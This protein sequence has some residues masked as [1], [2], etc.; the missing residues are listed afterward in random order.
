MPVAAKE[1]LK[2]AVEPVFGLAVSGRVAQAKDQLLISAPLAEVA[3]NVQDGPPFGQE[4]AMTGS[5]PLIGDVAATLD[6]R[7]AHVPP[8]A[9]GDESVKRARSPGV[10]VKTVLGTT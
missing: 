9:V 6:E 1:G 4:A 7:A 3:V 5:G 10:E 8:G 2:V